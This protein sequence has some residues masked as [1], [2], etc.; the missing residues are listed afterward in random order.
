MLEEGEVVPL[1]YMAKPLL[2]LRVAVVLESDGVE[3]RRR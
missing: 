3:L 2:Q 1:R